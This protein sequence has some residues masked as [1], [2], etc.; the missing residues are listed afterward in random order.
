MRLAGLDRLRIPATRGHV[1]GAGLAPE[2]PKR[3]PSLDL[4]R[5]LPV[6]ECPGQPLLYKNNV[7]VGMSTPEGGTRSLLQV[8]ATAAA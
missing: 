2:L 7:G 5:P 6:F 4:Y 1:Q 3:K 8:D